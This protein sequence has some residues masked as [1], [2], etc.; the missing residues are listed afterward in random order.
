M[1][2]QKVVNSSLAMVMIASGLLFGVDVQAEENI[3]YEEVFSEEN[4]LPVIV[5]EE[6]DSNV[7]GNGWTLNENGVFT[8][9]QDI[10]YDANQPFEWEVY[11]SQIQEVIVSEGVTQIPDY[12]FYGVDGKYA[13][14]SKVTMASTVKKIGSFAFANVSNLVEINLND[15]LQEIGDSAFSN[16]GVSNIDLSEDIIE[17]WEQNSNG[18]L[19][20]TGLVIT[21]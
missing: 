12:A 18:W 17:G 4:D 10:S 13:N 11:E 5:Q 6:S 16:I 15:G 9:F 20:L 21:I 1:K 14:L 19:Y 7:S 3:P 2:I 8:L